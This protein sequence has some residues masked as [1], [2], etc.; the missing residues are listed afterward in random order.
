MVT[1]EEDRDKDIEEK[2]KLEELLKDIDLLLQHI[3]FRIREDPTFYKPK[4]K[5]HRLEEDDYSLFPDEE[6]EDA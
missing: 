5:Y 2:K 4:R 1:T 3:I 6:D